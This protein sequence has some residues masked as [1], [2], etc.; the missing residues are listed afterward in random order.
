[1]GFL[2]DRAGL[3]GKVAVVVGG[4]QGTGQAV[5]LALAKAGVTIAFCDWAETELGETDAQ[6]EQ[7][8]R[9]LTPAHTLDVRDDE[10][11]AS[12]FGAV[13]KASDHIDILVNVAG[14][15]LRKPF[16]EQEPE[17][18]DATMRWNWT[19]ALNSI[20]HAIPRI[21]A[22][23][24]G[25]SVINF[26]TI[27]AHRAVPRY[28]LYGAAKAA[29]ANFTRSMALE[30]GPERIRFNSIA[31]D[32]TESPGMRRNVAPS[33]NP[34]RDAALRGEG[35]RMYIFIGPCRRRR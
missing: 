32:V 27:E 22:S 13:D 16:I 19:Y 10:K 18:W 6:L 11:L 31:I 2:E 34:E 1:M 3:A 12:F 23:G 26:T 30:F 17:E 4:A 20:R 24:R 28:A 15:V 21:Q 5:T 35:M 25:G 29:L 14:G 8:G 33:E 7:L 9:R